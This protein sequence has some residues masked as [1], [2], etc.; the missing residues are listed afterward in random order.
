MTEFIGFIAILG[1]ASIVI[2]G[3]IVMDGTDK[4]LPHAIRSSIFQTV[5]IMTTTGFA[6]EDFA[7][8]S[9]LPQTLLL[10]L[11]IIGG[12]SGST[13]GGIKVARLAVAV[14]LSLVTIE[15]SFRS[16]VVRQIR[17]NGRVLSERATNEIMMYLVLTGAIFLLSI[18]ILS[19][20]ET[21]FEMDTNL[22][23]VHACFFNIGPGFAEVGP[24]KTYA[25]F[26]PYSKLFLSLLMIMGRLELYAIL[27]LF[28]PAMWKRFE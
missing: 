20:F 15:R 25:P 17:M 26:H 1:T 19:L 22:S 7:K 28:A 10:V 27:A 5:S 6:T 3:I 8:W 9:S 18:Q 2:A 14:R 12:C 4:S 13:A 16:R 24:T 11:M 23:A 21:Y